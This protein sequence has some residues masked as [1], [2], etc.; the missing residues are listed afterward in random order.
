M[1]LIELM[2]RKKITEAFADIFKKSGLNKSNFEKKTGVPKGRLS[3]IV[4]GGMVPNN[5]D[6]KSVEQAFGVKLVVGQMRFEENV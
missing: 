3:Q 6:I 2:F 4:G 1:T 5:Q